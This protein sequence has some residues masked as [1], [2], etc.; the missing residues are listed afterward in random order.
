MFREIFFRCPI[1]PKAKGDSRSEP[2]SVSYRHRTCIGPCSIDPISSR[3][4]LRPKLIENGEHLD[5]RLARKPAASS[6][7]TPRDQSL[8]RLRRPQRQDQPGVFRLFVVRSVRRRCRLHRA[9][10]LR[11][12]GPVP[13][14]RRDSVRNRRSS[15]SLRRTSAWVHRSV[16][17]AGGRH[18]LTIRARSGLDNG[19][20]RGNVWA[21]VP[22]RHG[23]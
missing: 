23:P 18:G 7:A 13:R 12:D 5:S 19:S 3:G 9:R 6:A 14:N 21:Y 8:P 20:L 17:P 4:A 11:L 22:A 2:G 16:P 1:G 10:P 15:A